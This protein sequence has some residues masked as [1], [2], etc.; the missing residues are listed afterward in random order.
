MLWRNKNKVKW[1]RM[2]TICRAHQNKNWI[3]KQIKTSMM[4]GPLKLFRVRKHWP[5]K[6]SKMKIIQTKRTKSN[7]RKHR[8]PK[9]NWKSKIKKKNLSQT[10][11]KVMSQNT[12]TMM[13]KMM[14]RTQMPVKVILI[15]NSSSSAKELSRRGRTNTEARQRK[16]LVSLLTHLQLS[17]AAS[18]LVKTSN[19]LFLKIKQS[20]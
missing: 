5:K 11:T 20:L 17:Q 14:A 16:C 1:L 7:S 4:K 15:T 18:S 12:R 2:K 19:L 10:Q 6:S 13:R 9:W 8:K 3:Q